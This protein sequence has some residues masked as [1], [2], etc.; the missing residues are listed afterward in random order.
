MGATKVDIEVSKLVLNPG[1][2]ILICVT[3]K[4]PVELL[5]CIGERLRHLYPAN[6]VL[7]LQ[8]DGIVLE[9]IPMDKEAFAEAVREVLRQDIRQGS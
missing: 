6:K 9:T 7:I 8:G 5:A 2:S 1:D 4:Q 3:Q